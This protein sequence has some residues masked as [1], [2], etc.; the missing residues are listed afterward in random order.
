[1]DFQDIARQCAHIADEKRAEN[2]QILNLNGM[3]D[4][5]DYFVIAS[6]NNRRQLQTIAR[7]IEKRLKE[8]K[9]THLG[10]EGFGKA[11]WVLLDYGAVI[12]HLFLP[13]ARKYYD[14]DLLWGDAP[15]LK[16]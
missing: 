16:W 1:M 2:I 12:V 4:F 9:V 13:D 5:A 14:F 7:E 6:G 3:A 15:H 11:S 8:R 10:T